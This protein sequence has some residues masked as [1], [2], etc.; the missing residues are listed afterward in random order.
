M[1][2]SLLSWTVACATLLFVDAALSVE[3]SD[4]SMGVEPRAQWPALSIFVTSKDASLGSSYVMSAKP[5]VAHDLKSVLYDVSAHFDSGTGNKNPFASY[6]LAN[7]FAFMNYTNAGQAPLC[8]T[9][10]TGAYSI[11]PINAIV[12][13][14]MDYK[15]VAADNTDVC[16]KQFPINVQGTPFNLCEVADDANKLRLTSDKF[17]LVI[18]RVD[19]SAVPD[20]GNPSEGCKQV[21]NGFTVKT[22]GDGV[23]FTKLAPPA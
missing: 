7:G 11:P 20:L 15:G 4:R 18:S 16:T 19:H 12:Q 17:D 13:A 5:L 1:P 10:E 6:T 8:L 2:P 3:N 22:G 21:I 9:T 14:I 23:F